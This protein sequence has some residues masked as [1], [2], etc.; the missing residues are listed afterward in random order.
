MAPRWKRWSVVLMMLAA[1]GLPLIIWVAPA[2]F[3]DNC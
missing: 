1:I 3:C 2:L